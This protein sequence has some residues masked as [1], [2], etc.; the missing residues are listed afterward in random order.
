M[1]ILKSLFFAVLLVFVVFIGFA[2]MEYIQ[3]SVENSQPGKHVVVVD[4]LVKDLCQERMSIQKEF[5][6]FKLRTHELRVENM[7]LRAIVNEQDLTIS[8]LERQMYFLDIIVKNLK[9]QLNL[10][11]K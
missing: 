9:N 11:D 10:S 8:K 7:K 3:K 2:A 5:E 4:E 6:T 1:K